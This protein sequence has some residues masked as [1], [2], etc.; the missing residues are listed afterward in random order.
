MP[1]RILDLTGDYT[2][3]IFRGVVEISEDADHCVYRLPDL[4][5]EL[6]PPS[7]AWIEPSALIQYV[8][9]AAFTAESRTDHERRKV[10]EQR[11]PITAALDTPGATCRFRDI[12]F[13][14]PKRAIAD[15]EYV[16]FSL[17]GRSMARSQ[18]PLW[19][20]LHPDGFDHAV[21]WPMS[22]RGNFLGW[23]GQRP[24]RRAIYRTPSDPND[25]CAPEKV[26]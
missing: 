10:F 3:I 18:D 16:V 6:A 2:G 26:R 21:T 8:R 1:P 7:R 14:A 22:A 19:L 9:M 15:A 24:L 12:T 23:M 4:E 25:C 20:K 13:R 17:G 11:L 5:V